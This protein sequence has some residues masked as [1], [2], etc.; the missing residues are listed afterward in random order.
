MCT[1]SLFFLRSGWD[2]RV[3]LNKCTVI[4]LLLNVHFKLSFAPYNSSYFCDAQSNLFTISSFLDVFVLYVYR[5]IPYIQFLK[6]CTLM[7]EYLTFKSRNLM[8]HT[9]LVNL[10]IL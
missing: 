3:C 7:L 1:N 4:F 2:I 9:V 6:M 5:Y 10:V 8:L